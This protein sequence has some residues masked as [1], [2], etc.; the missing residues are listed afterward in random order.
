MIHTLIVLA[1]L[2]IAGYFAFE[3]VI[4]YKHATGTI[5]QRLIAAGKGSATIL[6]SRFVA[7]VTAGSVGL[8]ELAEWLN[9]PG[10]KDAIQAYLKPD[11]VAAFTLFVVIITEVARR[12]TL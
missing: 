5:W 12:R 11:Y 8:A 1:I 3:L 9:A 4:E 6:W 2:A 10:L 7:V